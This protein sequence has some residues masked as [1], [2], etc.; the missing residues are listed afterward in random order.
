MKFCLLQKYNCSPTSL[1]VSITDRKILRSSARTNAKSLLDW[2]KV[3]EGNFLAIF[4]Y[5]EV[6]LFNVISETGSGGLHRDSTNG[7]CSYFSRLNLS[8]R[9]LLN[10]F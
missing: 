5:R 1:I 3:T 10:S 4:S 2:D 7:F 9:S 8:V 6:L